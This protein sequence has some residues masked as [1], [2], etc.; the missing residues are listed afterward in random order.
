MF[1]LADAA[2][3]DRASAPRPPIPRPSGNS[4]IFVFL[5][6]PDFQFGPRESG[7]RVPALA[8]GPNKN[9]ERRDPQ[10]QRCAAAPPVRSPP[11]IRPE[12][13]RPPNAAVELLCRT[14]WPWTKAPPDLPSRVPALLPT[15]SAT[16]T[17]TT[18]DE[19]M[20]TPFLILPGS[21]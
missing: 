7:S 10:Q 5:G 21:L 9:G 2:S 11:P 16:A 19:H 17:A 13:T 3:A 15:K 1:W 14:P 6:I 12:P 20:P 18:G 8:L 4:L